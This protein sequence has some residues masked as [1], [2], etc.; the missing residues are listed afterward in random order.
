MVGLVNMSFTSMVRMGFANMGSS[1]RVCVKKNG[2]VSSRKVATS[3]RHDELSNVNTRK[4]A[5]SS[6]R[7]MA[8]VCVAPAF[9]IPNPARM[10]S[11]GGKTG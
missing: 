10:R 8:N 5:C 7:F 4:V 11:G 2:S 9:T 6:H 1:G 3:V